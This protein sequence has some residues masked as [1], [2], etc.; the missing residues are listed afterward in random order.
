MGREYLSGLSLR[1]RFSLFASAAYIVLGTIMVVRA[2]TTNFVVPLIVLGGVFI[3]LGLVRIRD[4][5]RWK[6]AAR[7]P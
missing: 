4:L 6:R 1:Q 5:I 2:V 7:A 3:A